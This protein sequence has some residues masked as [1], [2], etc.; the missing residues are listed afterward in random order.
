[1]DSVAATPKADDLTSR[2]FRWGDI[3]YLKPGVAAL[4]GD[5]KPRRPFV[6]VEVDGVSRNSDA[7]IVAAL[8]KYDS[9]KPMKHP[10]LNVFI[11]K[12]NVNRLVTSSFVVCNNLY[13]LK[14]DDF[15]EYIGN[16]TVMEMMEVVN[17][18]RVALIPTKTQGRGASKIIMS[19]RHK[20]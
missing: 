15:A 12:T 17:G 18:I 2:V 3:W 8:T 11:R 10:P 4:I 9:T 1:M 7:V 16:L 5:G 14:K 20:R 19:K 13:T 6:V